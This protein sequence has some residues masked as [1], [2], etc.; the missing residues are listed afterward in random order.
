[1]D[2]HRLIIFY[3][4]YSLND[5]SI[6]CQPIPNI[7]LFIGYHIYVALVNLTGLG[8]ST[9]ICGPVSG[10]LSGC[11]TIVGYFLLSIIAAVVVEVL[12]DQ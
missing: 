6:G 3:G 2:P 11:E 4:A 9:P 5:L 8:T 10:L 12:Q 7:F 1:M